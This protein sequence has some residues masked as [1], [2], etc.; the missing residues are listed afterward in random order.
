MLNIILFYVGTLVDDAG[1]LCL[2]SR[3]ML[4]FWAC[5]HNKKYNDKFQF[6]F[7]IERNSLKI[8]DQGS[9][10]DFRRQKFQYVF[11]Y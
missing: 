2:P 11:I 1:R 9:G 4:G 5:H 3:Q 10:F 6:R 7:L 8:E